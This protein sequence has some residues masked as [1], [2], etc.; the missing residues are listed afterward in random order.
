VHRTVFLGPPGAGKGTQADL[1]GEE[2]HLPHLSTGDLLRA[3]VAARTELGEEAE[4]HMKAGRL[5]PDDLVLRILAENL[6]RHDGE[7]GFILDGFPRNLAQAGALDRI[8][9]IDLVV[10]F[11]APTEL[12]V[13]RLSARRVC[14]KCQTV[15]NLETRPPRV[16]GRC[17]RDGTELV[18]RPDDHPEPIATRLKVYTEQTAPLLGFYRERGVLR[19]IDATGTLG[20]VTERIRQLFAAGR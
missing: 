20:Q 14:P 16:A 4:G 7:N 2:L 15:Y 1:L 3:A 5:V 13:H 12:L 11:E 8:T 9:P 18:H 6:K 19:P 10:S 17:D